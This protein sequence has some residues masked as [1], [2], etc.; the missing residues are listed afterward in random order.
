MSLHGSVSLTIC[1][2]NVNSIKY[3]VKILCKLSSS[4]C[5]TVYHLPCD[6][7]QV[8]NDKRCSQEH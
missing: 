2:Y 4:V 7:I 3:S 6:F 8:S 1:L 5:I